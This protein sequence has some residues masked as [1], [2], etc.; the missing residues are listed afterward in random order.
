MEEREERLTQ[1]ITILEKSVAK[2]TVYVEQI[3]NSGVD[4]RLRKVEI[5]MVNQQL[6]TKAIRWL[7]VTVSG[8]AIVLLLTYLFS[9]SIMS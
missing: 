7:A 2:L 9:N 4:D 8:S 6:V 1:L 5:D 3:K